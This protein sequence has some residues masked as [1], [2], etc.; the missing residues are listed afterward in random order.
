MGKNQPYARLPRAFLRQ[1]FDLP[2]DA[3][4]LEAQANQLRGSQSEN[5]VVLTVGKFSVVDIFDTNQFA[6]DARMDFLN[7]SVIDTGTFDYAA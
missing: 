4:P 3:H 1:T 2:G 7:W 5:R 6:H